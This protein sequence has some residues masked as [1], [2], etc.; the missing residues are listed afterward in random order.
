[1]TRATHGRYS[2][3]TRSIIGLP[4]TGTRGLG[5]VLPRREPRP[6]AGMM[7][8]RPRLRDS[9][10]PPLRGSVGRGWGRRI[11]G[12]AARVGRAEPSGHGRA[13]TLQAGDNGGALHT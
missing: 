6:A 13:E 3:M 10:G 11:G 9:V 8:T 7:S 12:R 2:S 4:F 5:I 1:M